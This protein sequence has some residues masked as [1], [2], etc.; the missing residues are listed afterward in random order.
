MV[1]M[2]IGILDDLKLDRVRLKAIVSNYLEI[3]NLNGD[4]YLYAEAE[5]LLADMNRLSFDLLFFDIRL[6]GM[7]GLDA[8]RKIRKARLETPL[9]FVTVAQDFALEGYEVQA[10]DFILKPFEKDKIFKT[11]DRIFKDKLRPQYITIKTERITAQIPI[12]DI[13]F[14]ETRSHYVE[15][16][17][18]GKTFKSY[19]TFKEFCSMLPQQLQFQSCFRG[20]VVNLDKVKKFE[21]QNLLLENGE[22]IPISR[23]KKTEIKRAYAAYAF[24]KTRR[25]CFFE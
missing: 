23:S 4:I 6:D 15:V 11:M 1:E 19:I 9:V 24:E 10:A 18:A 13:F 7:S 3:K 5:Q 12:D 14:A 16:H 20:I 2:K 25:D 21:D 8:A 22:R 17:T